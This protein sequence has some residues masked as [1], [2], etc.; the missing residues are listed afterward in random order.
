MLAAPVFG[1][2]DAAKAK[3]LRICVSGAAD[4]KAKVRPILEA[5]GQGIF[6]FGEQT[7]AANVV[8]LAG[9]FMIAAAMEAM[10]EALAMVRKSGVDPIATIGMLTTTLFAAPVYQGYG[11]AIAHQRF[12]PA[13]FRLPLGLKDIDLVLKTASEARAPMPTAS[14]LHDRFIAALAKGRAEMDWSALALGA[15]DDAG[16]TGPR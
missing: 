3:Q 13:G 1:R 6:D 8:K 5:M 4:A 2:P 14:L 11:A 10:A 12:T 7:E 15:A 16:L 9:N